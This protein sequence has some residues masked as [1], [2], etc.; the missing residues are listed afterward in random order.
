MT[1]DEAILD[2]WRRQCRIWDNLV[3]LLTPELLQSTPQGSWSVME[4]LAHVHE[5]RAY[6]FANV[7]GQKGWAF[8]A[9]YEKVGDEWRVI[10]DFKRIQTELHASG[11]AIASWLEQNLGREK[12]AG[13]YDHPALF[14]QHMIWHEGYHFGLVMLALRIAGAEPPEE[15]ECPNVWDLWRQPD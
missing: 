5:V 12:K 1:L 2:S 10:P 7:Q 3:T 15:W 14:L 11:E 6:W 8:E 13:N 4:H 9:L